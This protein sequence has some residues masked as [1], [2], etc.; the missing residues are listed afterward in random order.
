MSGETEQEPM[1]EAMVLT[2]R[3]QPVEGLSREDLIVA[4]HD[5]ARALER[6]RNCNQTN[7][8]MSQFFAD[9]KSR[10]AR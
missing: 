1:Q 2:W 4:V 7:V 5:F 9:V 6:E 8:E 3:G 10:F